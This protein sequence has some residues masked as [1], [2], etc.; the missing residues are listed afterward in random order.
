MVLSF[1]AL[2]E[3]SASNQLLLDQI[4]KKTN[5]EFEEFCSALHQTKQAGVIQNLLV[6]EGISKYLTRTEFLIEIKVTYGL[7]S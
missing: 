7:Y 5:K 3:E 2:P 1:Q 4:Q 6:T